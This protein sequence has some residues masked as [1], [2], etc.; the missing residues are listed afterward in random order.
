LID[1]RPAIA[2]VF[3]HHVDYY[4]RMTSLFEQA[5]RTVAVLPD[6]VLRDYAA[7]LLGTRQTIERAGLDDY[8]DLMIAMAQSDLSFPKPIDSA[9]RRDRRARARTLLQPRLRHAR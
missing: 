1:Q 8:A 5:V 2:F 6:D 7:G 9:E 4:S 3:F